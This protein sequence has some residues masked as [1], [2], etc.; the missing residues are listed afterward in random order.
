MRARNLFDVYTAHIRT[1]TNIHMHDTQ[2]GAI[3]LCN[4]MIDKY[5]L[6]SDIFDNPEECRPLRVGLCGRTPIR[7]LCFGLASLVFPSFCSAPSLCVAQL[8]EWWQ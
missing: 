5:G 2:E 4:H 8:A 7:G 3:D 1:L 6:T